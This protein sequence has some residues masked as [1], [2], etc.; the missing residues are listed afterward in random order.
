MQHINR[1]AAIGKLVV[2]GPLGKNSLAYRGIFIL[3]VKSLEE[4]KTLVATDTAI[5]A[6]LFSVELFNWYGAA[7]LLEYLKSQDRVEKK[8]L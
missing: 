6:E 2:A 8:K 5:K 4:A 1:L 7:A 3:D